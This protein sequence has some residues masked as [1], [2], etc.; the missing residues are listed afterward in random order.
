MIAERHMMKEYSNKIKR[1]EPLTERNSGF[2]FHCHHDILVEYVTDYAARVQY[3]K[4][5]K[6][7]DEQDLR[8]RLFKLIPDTRLPEVQAEWYKARAEW[9]KSLGE[10]EKAGAEWEKSLVEWNKAQAEWYK[11]FS[12]WNKAQAEWYKASAESEKALQELHEELCPDCPFN[13]NTIFSQK[14][15]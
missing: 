14:E 1:G 15:K 11:A 5:S 12:T 6:P 13:G 8:L 2:A 4:E 10:W 9:E 7:R 3:I